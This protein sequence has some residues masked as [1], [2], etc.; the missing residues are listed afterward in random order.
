MKFFIASPWRN[1]EA[2]KSLSNAL[3][4]R[5]HLAS[6][7]LNNG[8]NVLVGAPIVEESE[9][10]SPDSIK[11]WENNPVIKQVFEFDMQALRESDAVILLEPAGRS[12]LAEA[13]IAYGMGKK[14]VLVG[15]VEHPEVVV[16]CICGSRYASVDEFLGDLDSPL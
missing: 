2:V 8:A 7:F 9:K 6:S 10:T 11:N 16:Y 4:A 12:S 15:L 3:A 13:G 1:A 5:G 14:I